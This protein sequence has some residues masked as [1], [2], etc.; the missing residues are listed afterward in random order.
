MFA[1]L[2]NQYS[3]ETFDVKYI[4]TRRLNQ[5]ILEHFFLYIRSM[6]SGYDQATP[7][8]IKNRLKWYV[9]GKHSEHVLS[10]R[11]N[12]EGD[13]TCDSFITMTDI[14][15]SDSI[16]PANQL[17]EEEEEDVFEYSTNFGQ[18]SDNITEK[19]VEHSESEK[20]TEGMHKN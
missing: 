1:Y 17:S 4:L 11:T 5:D 16:Y 8:E 12:I 7:V 20:T 18:N 15:G 3:S 6:G 10:E 9:L 14:R 13:N 2:K 19:I